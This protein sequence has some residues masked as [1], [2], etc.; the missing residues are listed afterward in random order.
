MHIHKV[1]IAGNSKVVMPHG[2]SFLPSN[3]LKIHPQ[4]QHGGVQRLSPMSGNGLLL[5]PEL[6]CSYIGVKQ[7]TGINRLQQ[8]LKELEL[9]DGSKKNISFVL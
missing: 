5:S 1:L 8:K 9:K 7:G 6:G 2:G 4:S 3:K